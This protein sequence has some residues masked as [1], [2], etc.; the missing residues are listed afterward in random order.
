[1]TVDEIDFEESVVNVQG[2]GKKNGKCRSDALHL[3]RF[4]DTGST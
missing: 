2:K 4:R 1:M 3:M